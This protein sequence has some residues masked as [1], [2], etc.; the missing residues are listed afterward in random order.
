MGEL[1]DAIVV[2]N[3][4]ISYLEHWRSLTRPWGIPRVIDAL[5]NISLRINRGETTALIG[6]NGAGK[7]TLLRAMTGLVRPS[8]G[9]IT[10]LGR[11]VILAGT[12][13][14]FIPSM[15]GRENLRE[16]GHAYGVEEGEIEE[17]SETVQ[18]FAEI[19]DAIDRNVGGYSTG[20]RG[21]LG[22]GFITSLDPDILL[23]D[24]TLGVGDRIFREKAQK[25][26]REFIGRS[27]T[28]II[29][30]HSL[31]MAKEICK[32]GILLEQGVLE[33]NG[34]V[35]EAISKYVDLT[36]SGN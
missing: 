11:V 28:V 14:G 18:E 1:E 13:P 15:T 31:G 7:S 30:T 32:S 33:F 29:S 23:I 24:E 26:L 36:K 21:K 8:S 22:F 6:R 35:D 19:G 20:M 34:P 10:T 17:F 5:K 3:L 12:D 4:S 2:E 27:G 25:R 16:L 9:K